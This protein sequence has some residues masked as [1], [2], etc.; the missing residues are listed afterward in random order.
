MNLFSDE[1]ISVSVP[2]AA[3]TIIPVKGHQ[4]VVGTKADKNQTLT[5]NRERTSPSFGRTIL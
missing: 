4:R 1:E 3:A 2:E 5:Y